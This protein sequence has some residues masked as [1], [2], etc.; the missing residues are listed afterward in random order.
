[1]AN[2][3]GLVNQ[4]NT[5]TH[6]HTHPYER[7]RME[8]FCPQCRECSARSSRAL[9]H[10]Y[11]I[12]HYIPEPHTHRLASVRVLT[13]DFV[14]K[15]FTPSM[16]HMH[17]HTHTHTCRTMHNITSYY[18]C[19]ITLCAWP[20]SV[21]THANARHR[22]ACALLQFICIGKYL[23]DNAPLLYD[24]VEEIICYRSRTLFSADCYLFF[25]HI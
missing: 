15:L 13:V 20:A 8:T 9:R 14:V 22:H 5:N 2:N 25:S 11:I 18:T 10:D 16:S 17:A 21:I 6:T 12:E 24:G 23:D 3:C 4:T 7:S 19:G 1:M